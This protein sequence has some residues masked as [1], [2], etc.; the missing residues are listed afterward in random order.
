T[1]V[2]EINHAKQ[3]SQR[4][5][6]K[7]Q[8]DALNLNTYEKL[9]NVKDDFF[10]N[11]LNYPKSMLP[12]VDSSHKEKI[13]KYLNTEQWEDFAGTFYCCDYM[14][15]SSRNVQVKAIEQTA[16]QCYSFYNDDINNDKELLTYCKD[17]I[18]L[19]DNENYSSEYIEEL[20]KFQTLVDYNM[21]RC[22][23]LYSILFKINKD[24]PSKVYDKIYDEYNKD[25]KFQRKL[26]ETLIDTFENKNNIPESFDRSLFDNIDKLFVKNKETAQDTIN[27]Y[28]DE[29]KKEQEEKQRLAKEQEKNQSNDNQDVN[30]L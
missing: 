2:H 27:Y 13:E 8:R 22:K 11:F 3:N 7:N 26:C 19:H 6:L 17:I 20:N 15:I 16:K 25:Y 30:E 12:F 9:E 1:M 18:N 4:E 14:E 23:H 10:Y 24:I 28:K 5:H 21:A 29:V